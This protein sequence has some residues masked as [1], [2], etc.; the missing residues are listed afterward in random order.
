MNSTQLGGSLAAILVLAGVAWA[1]KLGRDTVIADRAEAMMLAEDALSG[2]EA[3]RAWLSREGRA[4]VVI[5][6]DRSIAV[7][8]MRGANPVA[9]R[10]KRPLCRLHGRSVVIMIGERLLRKATIDLMDCQEADAFLRAL[11][12]AGATIDKGVDSVG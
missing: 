10:L 12:A 2:F 5:G 1:L 3:D 11:D 4:A 7:L 6:R 9:R 8:C